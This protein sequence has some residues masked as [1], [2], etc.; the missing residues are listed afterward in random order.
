M[1]SGQHDEAAPQPGL[2]GRIWLAVA[3]VVAV[4]VSLMPPVATLARQYVFVESAQFVLFAI[5]APALIVLG[6]PWRLLRLSRAGDGI[7]AEAPAEAASGAAPGAPAV[8]GL[9]DEPARSTGWRP[10]GN[11]TGRSCVPR[12]SCS[13][14]S[15]PAWCG[16]SLRR[17]MP[18]LATRPW[19]WPN[20]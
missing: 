3:G 11:N 6:A 4:A 9:P 2:T 1:T 7:P 8:A 16:G 18:W 15:A 20:W 17:W 10:G 12:S 19:S 5:V 13:G 14:S